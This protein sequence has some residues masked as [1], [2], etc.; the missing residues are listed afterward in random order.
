MFFEMHVIA[1]HKLNGWLK[2]KLSGAC[3]TNV[4]LYT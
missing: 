2:H 4:D 3:F 1:K